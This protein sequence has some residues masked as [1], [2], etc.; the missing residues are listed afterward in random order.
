MRRRRRRLRLQ[1][2]FEE[3]HAVGEGDMASHGVGMLTLSEFYLI[4]LSAVVGIWF[5]RPRAVWLGSWLLD[6]AVAPCDQRVGHTSHPCKQRLV[7]TDNRQWV[8]VA[9]Q[10][11]TLNSD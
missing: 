1:Q 10:C 3:R 2:L 4:L 6:L 11:Q 9:T 7:Q 8:L 5:L